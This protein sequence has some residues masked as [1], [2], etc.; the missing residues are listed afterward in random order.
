MPDT[1]VFLDRDTADRELIERTVLALS[2]G[3]ASRLRAGGV[4]AATVAVKVRDSTFH[5]VSRQ[6]TLP[7]PTDLAD[8]I[9]RTALE[10]VRPEVRGKRRRQLFWRG[11]G[12]LTELVLT[13]GPQR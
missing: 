7:E 5:T 12:E 8:P 11:I 2:E 6:R 1:I 10:L 13:Q 3:V 4:R 9:F